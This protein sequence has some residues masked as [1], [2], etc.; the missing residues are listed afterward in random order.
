MMSGEES[1]IGQRNTPL[2]VGQHPREFHWLGGIVKA[3]QILNLLDAVFTLFWV[4]TG[5][6]KETNVLLQNLVSEDPVLFVV[7]KISLVSLGSFLL[8]SRR[9]RPTAVIAL[10]FVFIVYYYVLLVHLRFMSFVLA[11]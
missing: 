2:S 9:T 6:A 8:W 4:S 7:V 10:I 11:S 1:I 5:L 3:L